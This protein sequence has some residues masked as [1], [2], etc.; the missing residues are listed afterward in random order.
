MLAELILLLSAVNAD[1]RPCAYSEAGKQLTQHFEGYSPFIYDDVAG[2]KTVGFGHLL[3]PGEHFDEPLLPDEAAKL[4]DDD[5]SATVAGVNRLVKVK[6]RQGQADALIDF[7]FN[8][9]TG[10]LQKS[11]LLR[12]VNAGEHDQ[13]AEQFGRWDKAVVGGHLRPVPGLTRRRE[14]E[15]D[16]YAR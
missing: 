3:K 8:L 11:T 12:R 1:C 10:A 9:G 6:L 13:A 4:L 7:S 16:F 14:A 2:K 5:L 15:R